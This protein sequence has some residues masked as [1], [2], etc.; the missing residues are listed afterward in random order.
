MSAHAR[1]R[2]IEWCRPSVRCGLLLTAALLPSAVRAQDS[3]YAPLAAQIGASV[4]ALGMGG[5]WI[6][7]READALFVNPAF[8]GVS[9]QMA[10]GGGRYRDVA[11][12]VHAA[13]SIN[14]GG[15]GVAFGISALDYG[16]VPGG[17]TPWP[18]LGVRGADDSRRGTDVGFAVCRGHPSPAS[19]SRG[20]LTQC[21]ACAGDPEDAHLRKRAP[22]SASWRFSSPRRGSYRQ[23][24]PPQR[25]RT[26]V[27]RSHVCSLLRSSRWR[28][29]APTSPA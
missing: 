27:S 24:R 18:S 5:G 1:R 8:A 23:R 13:S 9:T 6:A 26:G 19:R 25:R 16:A 21:S 22:E 2:V 20:G 28:R 10:V 15:P 4:R 17:V 29:T 3:V 11:S 7:V 14:M 12:F